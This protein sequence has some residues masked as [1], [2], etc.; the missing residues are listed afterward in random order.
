MVK[1]CEYDENIE[2]L[3]NKQ[4]ETICE[5]HKLLVKFNDVLKNAFLLEEQKSN[6]VLNF[7]ETDKK[8]F[9]ELV[10]FCELI[11]FFIFVWMILIINCIACLFVSLVPSFLNNEIQYFQETKNFV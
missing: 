6:A 3:N 7:Y 5:Y 2:I 8:A 10:Y 4:M 1:I 9:C 11:D